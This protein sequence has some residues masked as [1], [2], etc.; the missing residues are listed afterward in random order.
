MT[1][2]NS[3]RIPDE[4]KV[5][6]LIPKE[7]FDRFSETQEQILKHLQ[8]GDTSLPGLGDFI[9]REEAER[10]LGRKGTTLWKLRK[11]GKIKSSKMGSEVFYSRESIL[12]YLKKNL[13]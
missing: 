4:N 11:E 5:F 2:K 12:D 9:S 13:K 6:I 8:G 10:I 3:F 7:D 1:Q